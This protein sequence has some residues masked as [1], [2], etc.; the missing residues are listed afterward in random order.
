MR[1]GETVWIVGQSRDYKTSSWDFQ[2]IFVT[3]AEAV[4]A[5]VQ[6]NYFVGPAVLGQVL[7]P[8]SQD[9]PGSYYPAELC[10]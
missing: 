10:A 1:N 8:E 6:P 9:W 7:P 3:E 4:A 2:G 5:C